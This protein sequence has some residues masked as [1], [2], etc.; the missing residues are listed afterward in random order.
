MSVNYGEN[1]A[2]YAFNVVKY[3]VIMYFSPGFNHHIKS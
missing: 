1:I 2:C 3:V